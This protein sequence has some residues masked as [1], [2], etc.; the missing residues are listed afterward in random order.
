[1]KN[2]CAA[3]LNFSGSCYCAHIGLSDISP[4]LAH[5]LATPDP[6]AVFVFYVLFLPASRSF[7][8]SILL[9]KNP[10][11]LFCNPTIL[12]SQVQIPSSLRNIPIYLS[13]LLCDSVFI[14]SLIHS[15]MIERM[16][17]ECFLSLYNVDQ[18]VM[19]CTE[20]ICNH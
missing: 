4:I 15:K 13:H 1:M 6:C 7:A 16:Q 20:E 14:N 9:N 5:S 11:L 19:W 10:S 12:S 17:W 3:I 8:L 18:P 2:D